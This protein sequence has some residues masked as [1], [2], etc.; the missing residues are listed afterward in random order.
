MKYLNF[1]SIIQYRIPINDDGT[2][3]N[4]EIINKWT[5]PYGEFKNKK[6]SF[7]QATITTGE[8]IEL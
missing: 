4:P 8:V 3:G 7:K 1:Q 5:L 6:K 2:P